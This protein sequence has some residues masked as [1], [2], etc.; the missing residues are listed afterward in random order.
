MK[1][2]KKNQK[3]RKKSKEVALN[4]HV[5]NIGWKSKERNSL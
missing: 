1:K 5:N 4:L 2:N 3:N